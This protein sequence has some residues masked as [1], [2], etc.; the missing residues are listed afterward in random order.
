VDIRLTVDSAFPVLTAT[1]PEMAGR[2][3]L[4]AEGGNLRVNVAPGARLII[5]G[6]QYMLTQFHLHWPAEH[7]HNGQLDSVEIHMVHEK[8]GDRRSL[9][10][11][12]TWVVPGDATPAWDE[13]WA[14]FP[15]A[16]TVPVRVNVAALFHIGVLA[17]DELFTYCGTLT[18]RPYDPGVTWLIRARPITFSPDQIKRLHHIMPRYTHHPRPLHVPIQR[19]P[20]S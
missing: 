13:L 6:E 12:S 17:R 4:N 11:V 15:T 9:A 7:R 5:A 18:S 14:R 20:G 19:H 8:V 2:A 1:Y 3:F 16:D 10:V